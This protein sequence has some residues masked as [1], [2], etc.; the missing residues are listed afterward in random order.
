MFKEIHFIN[1]WHNGDIHNSRGVIKNIIQHFPDA[2]YYHHHKHGKKVLQD[3][4]GIYSDELLGEKFKEIVTIIDDKVYINTWL[5]LVLPNK[6]QLCSWGCNC[7]S[8]KELLN[9]IL[10]TLNKDKFLSNEFDTIP[11]INFLKFNVS[12]VDTF[13]KT[14]K[15]KK[16]LVCNGETLSGQSYNF[17][18]MPFVINLAIKYQNIDFIL[19]HKENVVKDNIFYTDDII[20]QSKSDLN[21]ISYLS[22]ACSIIVGR[23]SG[24]FMFSQTFNS[25]IDKDKTFIAFCN[26][27]E[28]AFLTEKTLCKKIWSNNYHPD[29][30]FNILDSELNKLG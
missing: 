9:H 21:E 10:I 13:L 1:D 11:D 26:L 20:Q 17:S 16:I 4:P 23:A 7:I 15:N 27:R 2:E 3:I 24:P 6:I 18:F 22:T 29:N 25:L 28:N 30:I 14:H 5:G 8:N 19:T 12:N